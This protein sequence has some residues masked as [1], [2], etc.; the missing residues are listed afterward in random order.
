MNV[1]LLKNFNNY[2]NRKIK[3]YSKIDDYE[4]YFIDITGEGA[5]YTSYNFNPNDGV[6]TSI[7][8]GK[9]EW[10]DIPDYCIVQNPST[11]EI[12]SRWY[13]IE[14]DRT[15]GGQ[16]NLT[17]RRDL[18]A[19]YWN[20]VINADTY[21]EKATINDDSVFIYNNEQLAVN[22]IK[23]RQTE[24]IDNSSS[25]WLVGY[26]SSKQDSDITITAS[27]PIDYNISVPNI[28]QWE[29]YK[30]SNLAPSSEKENACTQLSS[31]NLKVQ[32][33][34]Y[35]QP[36]EATNIF[37][38]NLTGSGNPYIT[39]G[40]VYDKSKLELYFDKQKANP[41]DINNAMQEISS[42]LQKENILNL[43]KEQSNY[44]DYYT[45][46][47]A[48]N[49]QIIY[50]QANDKYY[51]ISVRSLDAPALSYK[52]TVT[53]QQDLDL[54]S[55]VLGNRVS[56]DYQNKADVFLTNGAIRRSQNLGTR[57]ET[58]FEV[59]LAVK[60]L[61][62]NLEEVFGV[63]STLTIP[64]SVKTLKDAPYKMFCMPYKIGGDFA[65][66]KGNEVYTMN[67]DTSMAIMTK[68][69]SELSG[70][71][72]LYDAQILPYCPCKDYINQFNNFSFDTLI[73]GELPEEG[74]DYVLVK[75]KD[76]VIQGFI[77]FCDYASFNT[78]VNETIHIN[79]V[80]ISNEC[81]KYRICSPNFNGAFEFNA[82]KNGG[83]QG[84]NVTCT[85]KP[86]SPYIKVAPSFGNLYGK[87]FK[88]PRGLICGGDFG[89]PLLNDR[90]ATYEINNKNYL[91]SFNR[92]IENMEVQQKYQR[93]GDI[94]GSITGTISGA[95]TGA[96]SGAM[97]GGGVGAIAGGVVG[98]VSSAAGG[99]ADILINEQLRTEAIDY[100]K[101][102]FNYSLQ[103]IQ[104]L[105][106]TLSRVSSLTAD[107]TIFPV[108]EYYTCKEEEKEAFANKIAYNG[109]TLM[110]I[111]KI[112][113]YINN[114]WSYK[115]KIFSKGYVKG[116]LIRL[117]ETGINEEFHLVK[118]I[119]NEL[120]KGVYI[121]IWE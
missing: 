1:Y 7:V 40:T 88:D 4:D 27:K 89:L 10:I 53:S 66:I 15:R 16:Y 67:K 76:E 114:T 119:S 41:S 61:K 112:K 101:D 93:V 107:N 58:S 46:Y 32:I 13:V 92:Q 72:V 79:N 74:V 55:Y 117:E 99:V 38:Y 3:F 54:V 59:I 103:N 116:Q 71:S 73:S 33:A 25:A 18:L 83:V 12:D 49:G 50:D 21:I 17:L 48:I 34:N 106:Y 105:P 8:I 6:N 113:D 42:Q 91:N 97:M 43:A 81:D 56:I 23:T 95:A 57:A 31:A 115:N 29:Y 37:N 80:K 2:Y 20:N 24:L 78:V 65:F 68:L 52:P 28:N 60:D 9:G 30:Y 75:G 51:S 94:V 90:W 77:M 87:N 35:L 110:C 121:E 39:N 96:L 5:G 84:F 82:A 19:D 102:Q 100:T 45:V 108:L 62:I 26:L 70:G 22:Q 14:C 44:F 109:M 36:G 111:G 120:Y 63:T 85:Y 11:G 86:Y 98:G 104:A 69:V 64:T 118:E 47:N